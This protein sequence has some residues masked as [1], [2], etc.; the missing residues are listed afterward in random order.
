MA[1]LPT[2]R[3]RGSNVPRTAQTRQTTPDHVAR[4]GGGGWWKVLVGVLIVVGL[5]GGAALWALSKLGHLSIFQ[6][7]GC[8]ASSSAGSMSLDLAQAQNASTI[9]A[10]G[11]SLNVPT[12]GIRVALAT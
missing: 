12:F 8:T 2:T 3:G 9:T 1:P 5:L 6:T 10:V 7:N 11:V 4:G